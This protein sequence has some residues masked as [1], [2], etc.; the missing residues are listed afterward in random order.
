MTL[1]ADAVEIMLELN[2]SMQQDGKVEYKDFF[3][4][5]YVQHWVTQNVWLCP[6]TSF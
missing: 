2:I 1:A 5:I 4:R 6:K 3:S